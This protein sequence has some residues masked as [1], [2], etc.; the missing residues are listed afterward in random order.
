MISKSMMNLL[1]RR[2]LASPLVAT[3]ARSMGGGE[4]KPNMPS[5]ETN[6][7]VVFVGK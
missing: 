5:T 2:S 3:Q 7:D 1:S 6:F 4:K